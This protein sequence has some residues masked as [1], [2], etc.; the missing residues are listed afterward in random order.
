MLGRGGAAVVFAAE[1]LLV[2]RPAALKLP[3]VDPELREILF[4]RLRRET[5]ALSR[6][7]HPGIV[8]V[9]DAGDSEGVPFLAME[10]LEGRT[11]GGLVAARGR[12]EPDEVVKV[13]LELAAGLH[14]VHGAGIV[15]RDVKP[16][17]VLVT[18]EA[19]SRVHLYDFGV[20]KLGQGPDMPQSKL[21]VSGAI[22]GTPEYMPAEA[23]RKARSSCSSTSCTRWSAPAQPKARGRRPTC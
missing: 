16:E 23:R 9:V 1:H 21:T 22:L 3:H 13:G 17:N 20:A 8:D 19:N 18:A 12:L 5:E 14:A 7:R 4:A 6:V 2:K 10:L 15:H 11:L